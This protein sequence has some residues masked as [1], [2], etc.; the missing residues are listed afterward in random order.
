[1]EAGDPEETARKLVTIVRDRIPSRFGL[2]AVRDVQVLCPINRGGVGARS[3]NIALQSVLNP[4]AETKVERFG[5]TYA[6]DDKVMQVVNAYERD[7]FNGD[8]GVVTRVD[9][10][11][12]ELVANFEG[13]DVAYGFGELD[14]LSLAYATTIHKSQGSEYPAVVIPLT[15]QHYTIWRAICCIR[16]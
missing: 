6:A 2:D 11:E 10:D 1:M 9:P 7:V 16:A 5:S 3:L 4:L 14:E 12:G 13:R 8:L 15:T